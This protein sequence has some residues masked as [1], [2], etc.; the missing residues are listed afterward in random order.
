MYA[1]ASFAVAQAKAKPS[2]IPV[3]TGFIALAQLTGGTIALA[4]SNAVFLDKATRMI[5]NILPGA[6]QQAVEGAVSGAGSQLFQ[7]LDPSTRQEVL[8]AVTEAIQTVYILPITGAS[9]SILLSLFM[10]REKVCRRE[11]FLKADHVR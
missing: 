11:D 6:S 3:A 10:P 8:H 4:I 9:M 2:E 7:T 1:Q 5:L